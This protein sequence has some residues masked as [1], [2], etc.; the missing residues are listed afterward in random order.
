MLGVY[1]K[2]ATDYECDAV[3]EPLSAFL[4]RRRIC[5]DAEKKKEDIKRNLTD[6]FSE[7]L[8]SS[9][10]GKQM[11]PIININITLNTDIGTVSDPKIGN[12]NGNIVIKKEESDKIGLQKIKLEDRALSPFAP[13]KSKPMDGN[14]SSVRTEIELDGQWPHVNVDLIPQSV[15]DGG[16]IILHSDIPVQTSPPNEPKMDL[17]DL[18]KV[19]SDADL[20]S[21]QDILMRTKEAR[22][23]GDNAIGIFRQ[24]PKTESSGTAQKEGSKVVGNLQILPFQSAGHSMLSL[25]CANVTQSAAIGPFGSS[26]NF[27]SVSMNPFGN[28]NESSLMK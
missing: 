1:Y 13:V 27:P 6:L 18:P 5:K 15:K 19:R 9:L 17:N 22:H 24:I 12:N 28:I 4:Q 25:S 3:D 2:I 8:S 11:R 26:L 10:G 16:V 20:N 7:A 21:L 23:Y 14:K